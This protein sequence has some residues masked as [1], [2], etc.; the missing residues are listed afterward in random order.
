MYFSEKNL[1]KLREKPK[2]EFVPKIGRKEFEQYSYYHKFLLQLR[3]LI[4]PNLKQN[5]FLY[6]KKQFTGEN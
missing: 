1:I 4:I 3:I 6:L 5:G 2:Y